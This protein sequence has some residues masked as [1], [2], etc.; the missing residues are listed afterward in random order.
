MYP[1]FLTAPMREELTRLGARELRTAADVDRTLTETDGTVMVV[2]SHGPGV[3]GQ[4]SGR[5]TA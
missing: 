1:E 4:G 5:V 2:M 3:R